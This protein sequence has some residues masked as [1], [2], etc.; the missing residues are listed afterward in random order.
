MATT[1]HHF[2]RLAPELRAQIW[3]LAAAPR[4]VHIRITETSRNY[5]YVSL[6]PPPAIM[7]VCKESRQHAPYQKA[8]FTTF[9]GKPESEVSYIW[10][11]FQEDMVCIAD[12]KV[13]R[14]APHE[15]DI[16]RL[17]FTVPTGYFGDIFYDYWFHHSNEV[18]EEFTALRELHLAI[19]DHV[20]IWGTTVS[21]PG[22]GGC[23]RENVRFLDVKTGLLLTGPQLEMA[24]NWADQD[25]GRVLY[26]DDFDYELQF[27]IDNETGLNLSELA[28]ID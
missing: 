2:S 22:Y 12:E 13:E 5:S 7:H 3:G 15:A 11:N 20:L 14:L 1:F 10:V 23:P 18:L 26:M 19:V 24:Y 17:R 9:P 21:G 4:I 27:M 6:N 16:Q 25:G 8:F 28:E